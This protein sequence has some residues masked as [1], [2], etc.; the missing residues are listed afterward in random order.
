MIND[1][2]DHSN[3]DHMLKL[4]GEILFQ[5]PNFINSQNI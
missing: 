2:K 1:K 5:L 4:I 3:F